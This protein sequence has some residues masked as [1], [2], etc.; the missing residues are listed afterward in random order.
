MSAAATDQ[1]ALLERIAALEQRVRELERNAPDDQAS[2]LVFSGEMD[3]LLAAFIVATGASAMGMKVSMYFTFWGLQAIK[4]KTVYAQKPITEQMVSAMLATGPA[5]VG[6]SR[7]NM[8][9]MG[10]IFFRHIMKMNH[11][12]TLP[13][14][15]AVAKDLEVRMIGCE[16]SMGVMG[17]RREELMDE[18]EYGGVAT[19]LEDAMNSKLTLFI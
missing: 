10:P 5:S 6:T 15:I 13:G 1:A 17:I 12:E 7:L 2:I 19:Y 3:N 8:M 18:L 11:V 16:M 4:K 14:L 9:G